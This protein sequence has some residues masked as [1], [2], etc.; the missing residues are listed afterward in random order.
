MTKQ[1]LDFV[2]VGGQKCGTT[3]LAGQLAQLE[4]VNFCREKEPHF[5]SKTNSVEDNLS[6]YFSLYEAC[7][8][9]LLG[10]ASTTYSFVDE[11]PETP[12][13]LYQHNPALKVVFLLRDPVARIESH[14]NHR[15]RNGTIANR[16]SDS[17]GKHPCFIE[18]SLYA[19][20]LEAYLAVFPKEQIKVLFFEDYI[21]QPYI[22]LSQVCEFLS[23]EIPDEDSLNLRAQNVSDASLKFSDKPLAKAI[24]KLI[25]RLPFA[26]K[27]SRFLPIKIRFDAQ[28]KRL[29]WLALEHDVMALEQLLEVSCQ[30]W[31]DKYTFSE[32]DRIQ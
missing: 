2:I 27:L 8:G 20:Q 24:F 22:V 15:L 10:E 5:F 1:Q 23:L 4:E 11:Y 19:R 12:E 14:F 13:R 29:L 9:T 18:R 21:K 3:S 32:T 16:P 25:E 17:V 28:F 31:R 6:S 26:Y 30:R 7:E